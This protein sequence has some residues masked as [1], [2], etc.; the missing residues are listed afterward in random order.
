M[1]I[2]VVELVEGL[3][4]SFLKLSVQSLLPCEGEGFFLNKTTCRQTAYHFNAELSI[5]TTDFGSTV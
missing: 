2:L 3:I 1:I 4:Q 5:T